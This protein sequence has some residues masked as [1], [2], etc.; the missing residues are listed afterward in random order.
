M[1]L[2]YKNNY[3]EELADIF[4]DIYYNPPFNYKWMSRSSITKY[5][6]DFENTPNFR[7]FIFAQNNKIRG[8]CLGV[9][10]KRFKNKR[11]YINEIFISR[12][13]QNKGLGKEF[14][15]Q[16]EKILSAEGVEIIE[17]VTEENIPSFT[18]YKKSGFIASD[19]I[20]YL[21]KPIKI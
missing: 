6:I 20:K 19:N 1:V 14:L 7:G 11:Y 16:S 8:G 12:A 2:N 15:L 18:F 10:N 4:F 3:R 9:I 17:L 13:M 21:I 5:F